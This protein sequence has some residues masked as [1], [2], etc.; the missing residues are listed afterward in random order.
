MHFPH[1]TESSHSQ[2]PRYPF[3]AK[4]Y[5]C[6]MYT[7]QVD[8]KTW[9]ELVGQPP[10][11]MLGHL[12]S[13]YQPAGDFPGCL[14]SE[15]FSGGALST[16]LF[17]RFIFQLIILVSQKQNYR[18]SQK[19]K[20]IWCRDFLELWTLMDQS[21]VPIWQVCCLCAE[22]QSECISLMESV[23]LRSEALLKI[24]TQTQ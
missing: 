23:V 10:T 4:A 9:K 8:S 16:K 21:F 5:V 22:F 24:Q 2:Q 11:K 7:L 15:P 3:S 12:V 19:G 18:R 13:V 17:S 20:V 1:W 6:A 14:K